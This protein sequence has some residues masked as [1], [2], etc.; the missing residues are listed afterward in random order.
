MLRMRSMTDTQQRRDTADGGEHTAGQ[1]PAPSPSPRAERWHSGAEAGGGRG[2][3]AWFPWVLA[4]SFLLLG[5][6][7]APFDVAIARWFATTRLPGDLGK[8]VMLS[9]AFAHGVGA[10]T[11]L[12]AA[13]LLDPR[14]HGWR[15]IAGVVA[16]SFGGGL[17]TDVIKLF[18]DRV[19]P[20]ALDFE[21]VQTTLGTFASPPGLGGSDLHS[22][23]SGHSAVAAGLAC[24]LAALYPR[25]RWLFACVGAMAC[26]QRI[27]AS[28][29][30]PSDVATGAAIG[31]V[32]AT[33][34]ARLTAI[35][36]GVDAYNRQ[37]C[38]SL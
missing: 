6:A 16:G 35:P 15:R 3:L 32:V 34:C 14:F 13:W 28:A 18:V 31:I 17:V 25:G 19:R 8:A 23:P 10:A 4:V 36:Q 37:S 2:G 30:Y 24:T 9:E 7:V 29:H 21:A 26:F 27:A 5:A 38:D 11:V 33:A 1:A 22:F 12:V 20:R